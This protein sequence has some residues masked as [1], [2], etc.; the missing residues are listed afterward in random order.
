MFS[1]HLDCYIG[2]MYTKAKQKK[3]PCCSR[4]LTKPVDITHIAQNFTHHIPR[5]KISNS[6]G[7][8]KSSVPTSHRCP[9]IRMDGIVQLIQFDTSLHKLNKRLQLSRLNYRDPVS[10]IKS[11]SPNSWRTTREDRSNST[12]RKSVRSPQKKKKN[13]KRRCKINTFQAALRNWNF[14][15]KYCLRACRRRC[16]YESRQKNWRL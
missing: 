14:F 3:P 1:L 6:P 15:K 16:G 13:K 4:N 12:S 7:N 5:V 8:T 9:N 10:I 2:Y 11:R